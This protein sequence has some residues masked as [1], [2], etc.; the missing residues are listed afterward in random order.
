MLNDHL[1]QQAIRRENIHHPILNLL[2]NQNLSAFLTQYHS[3]A[4][5]RQGRQ[6][7]RQ[8]LGFF[9]DDVE[10]INFEFNELELIAVWYRI[11]QELNMPPYDT[12]GIIAT[13]HASQVLPERK[14]FTRHVFEQLKYPDNAFK[15]RKTAL[16]YREK[17]GAI[18]QIADNISVYV[19]G[20]NLSPGDVFELIKSGE[21]EKMQ[22]A[23]EII[24]SQ[25]TDETS[26]FL[27]Y[28]G[29][30]FTNGKLHQYV[31]LEKIIEKL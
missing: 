29:E 16:A 20:H 12:A 14:G 10:Q 27:K 15:D 24:D 31:Y 28:I 6:Y 9:A 17:L 30:R 22:R 4:D 23:Q 21:P 5:Y 19:N 13:A 2:E 8:N 18:N 1:V 26:Q 3:I 7:A 25:K 11:E